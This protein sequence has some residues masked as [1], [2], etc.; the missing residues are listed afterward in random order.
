MLLVTSKS[1]G[2]WII[3]KGGRSPD[4]NDAM[5]AAR[6]ALEE[7]GVKGRVHQTPIGSYIHHSERRG[8]VVVSVY[9]LVVEE[10]L[11]QWQEQN[12]RSRLWASPGEA[13]A[14]TTQPG[15]RQFLLDLG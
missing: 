3:P 5:A 6:E 10:Q 7:A 4:L 14:L 2:E 11:P 1:D 15:L 9:K 12:A 8:A 13:A